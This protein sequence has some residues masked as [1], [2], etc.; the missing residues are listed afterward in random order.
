VA[1]LRR[2]DCNGPGIRRLRHGR[3]FRY[4]RQGGKPVR[5]PRLLE[6]IRALAIPPAWDDV[7]ICADALGHIQATGY[8]DAGRKQYLYHEKWHERQGRLKFDR[9]L[10]FGA[11]LP[12][13]REH[14]V[15]DLSRRGLVRARV[16][17]CAIR[18]LDLGFFRIG[19]EDYAIEN[20]TYGLATLRQRHVRLKAGKAEFDFRAKG[21]Q[22]HVQVVADP[23]VLPTVR[24]LK[25]RRRGG[26]KLLVYW[27]P[28]RWENVGS[29]EINEYLKEVAGEEFSAKDFRTWNATV[30]AA[31][32]LAGD[33]GRP[34]S[35]A[36]RKKAAT[37]AV[38]QVAAYLSNTPAVCRR[39]YIDPRT[40]DRFDSGET[41][42]AALK[43]IV[44][45][46]DP[47]EFPDRERIERA[48]LRLL[49]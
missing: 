42:H 7:W 36:A 4:V 24:A 20:D 46:S 28:P 27:K 41:I 38:K 48:V 16:L 3:G 23:L 22:R 39:S 10:D 47:S 26:T 29:A 33:D 25:H 1:R 19:G 32:A 31:V 30:L 13:V 15:R 44:D 37:G 14:V 17:A 35:P 43:R 8:D 21:G 5:D 49:R 2:A 9:L 40:L 11:V 18:L 45:R 34:R 6:R 12:R